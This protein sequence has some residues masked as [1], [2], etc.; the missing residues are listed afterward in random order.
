MSISYRNR[1]KAIKRAN[2]R[3]ER[4]DRLDPKGHIPQ[5]VFN[6]V[7]ADWYRKIIGRPLGTLADLVGRGK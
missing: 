7:Q 2:K 3:L 5:N 1:K 6:Q 4:L